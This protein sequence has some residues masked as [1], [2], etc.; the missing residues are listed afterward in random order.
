[1][2]FSDD[3]TLEEEPELDLHEMEVELR[4]LSTT[5]TNVEVIKLTRYLRSLLREV[6]FIKRYLQD[7]ANDEKKAPN[8]RKK[9]GATRS[10]RLGSE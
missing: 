1:M 2:R 7:R 10:R 6:Y 9:N 4:K 3:D 8:K 5:T